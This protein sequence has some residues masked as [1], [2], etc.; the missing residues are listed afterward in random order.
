MPEV[1]VGR[2]PI[3]NKQLKIYG[4]ELLFRSDGNPANAF[5]QIGADGATSTTII[6][7]YLEMGLEKL[8]GKH[9]AFINLTEQFL[10]N[11]NALPIEPRQVVLEILEDIEITPVIIEAVK[12]LKDRGFTLALD[13][14][15][16]NPAHKPLMAYIDIV[17]IDI[18]Q[19][20]QQQ[21]EQHV[22]ILKT[23]NIKLLAEKIETM[24][25]FFLCHRLGFEYFQGYFLSKPRV[26]KKTT[27]GT[28]KMAVLNL[29]SVLMNPE[30]EPGDIEEAL[31]FDVSFSYKMLK[32]INSAI[33]N[34]TRE[35][36][37]IRQAIVILGRK[38]LTSWASLMAL[39][40]MDDRPTE[41]VHMIMVRAKMCEILAEQASLPE[42]ESY[43][44]VGM[45]SG[46]D[47]LMERELAD[48]IKP[49]PLKQSIIDALLTHQGD[50]GEALACVLAYEVS[51]YQ[52][53]KFKSLH[54]DEIFVA[55]IEAVSWANMVL[56]A[57]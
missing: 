32:L 18:M 30:S 8:V 38:K 28:S 20:S 9:L 31:G 48:L 41:M 40:S 34:L 55:N 49:L 27:L 57:K 2:Q 4:Y 3:Y 5:Q 1:F 12:R 19:L 54:P 36:N 37:S 42:P 39:S 51:D 56:D 50:Y 16:Y 52:K 17:K 22:S 24:D 14:Y 33:F 11:E 7:C 44:I 29:L 53:S 6:N 23:F 45:L 10:I 25:E 35:I 26:I 13:D 46:L 43:F 15:I 21:L 47:I